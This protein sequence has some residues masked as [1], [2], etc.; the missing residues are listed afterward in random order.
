MLAVV[1]KG[2]LESVVDVKDSELRL[3]RLSRLIETA[4]V[5]ERDQDAGAFGEPKLDVLDLP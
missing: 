1:A 2:L 5:V 3:R 4:V